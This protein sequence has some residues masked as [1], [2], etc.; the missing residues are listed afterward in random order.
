MIFENSSKPLNIDNILHIQILFTKQNIL[1]NLLN[2]Y[3]IIIYQ[4]IDF[5]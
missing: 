4:T 5:K 2:R 1:E 3:K